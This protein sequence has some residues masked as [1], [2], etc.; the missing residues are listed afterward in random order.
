M[1][2]LIISEYWYPEVKGG[3]EKSALLL[4]EAVSKKHDVTVLTSKTSKQTKDTVK[5]LRELSTGKNPGSIFSNIKR[6]FVYERSMRSWLRKNLNNYDVAHCM[7]M[8]SMS[9]VKLKNEFPDVLFVAHVNSYISFCP[10]GDLMLNGE[11]ECWEKCTWSQFN[12]CFS[13]SDEF[14]KMKNS[15]YFRY[16]PILRKILYRRYAKFENLMLKFDVL[17]PISEYVK[18]RISKTGFKGK[19]VVVPNIVESKQIK[20]KFSWKMPIRI[21]Y[22]GALT[23]AKGVDVLLKSLEGLKDYELNLFGSGPLK[24]WISEYSKQKQLNV[25]VHCFTDKI[26]DIYLNSDLIVFPSVWPEPFGRVA[27]EAAEFSTP[28]I[29]SDAGGLKEILNKE[30]LVSAGSA[31]E[32]HDKIRKFIIGFKV[33]KVKQTKLNLELYSSKRAAYLMGGVYNE[34]CNNLRHKT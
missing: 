22:L 34:T 2:V 21:S 26:S 31:K 6:L 12:S 27:I 29:A 33:N 18:K 20:R 11:K 17:I 14:G 15:C 5:V 8:T 1:K 4:A 28:I 30:R 23:K 13:H 10:K 24:K 3:G 7:N 32:L 9:A 25:K 19:L 16:N